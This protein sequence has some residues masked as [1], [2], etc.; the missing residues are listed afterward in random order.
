[1]DQ[2]LDKGHLVG[3][4]CSFCPRQSF[5]LPLPSCASPWTP[6]LLGDVRIIQ[7]RQDP[8]E[9]HQIFCVSARPLWKAKLGRRDWSMSA[10]HQDMLLEKCRWWEENTAF[11]SLPAV[12]SEALCFHFCLS[13]A[14]VTRQSKA[15]ALFS[16]LLIISMWRPCLAILDFLLNLPSGYW[17]YGLA[18]PGAVRNFLGGPRFPRI[19]KPPRESPNGE[20][21][22][23]CPQGTVCL[24]CFSWAAL[25]FLTVKNPVLFLQEKQ[26]PCRSP[27]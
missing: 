8:Q 7:Q 11:L 2:N 4:Q 15:F 19:Q 13:S 20:S 24:C 10:L 26:P 22:Q 16:L 1:M 6:G 17:V 18:V 12:T 23:I 3:T 14:M 9:L 25:G 5:W 21:P 27:S